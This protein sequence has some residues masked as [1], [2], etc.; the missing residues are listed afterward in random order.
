[1]KIMRLFM[2][3]ALLVFVF[4]ARSSEKSEDFIKAKE[5]F[6]KAV[7]S[8]NYREAKQFLEEL[9]PLMKYDIKQSKKSIH[10]LKKEDA[11]DL[12]KQS[13]KALDRKAEIYKSLS[14]L[15][16]VSPAALRVKAKNILKLVLEFDE[17]AQAEEA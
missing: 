17:L 6:S 5:A 13:E 9:L 8:N 7:E 12:L 3:L 14:H 16:D 2:A 4:N 10:S 15:V 1:M 11:D